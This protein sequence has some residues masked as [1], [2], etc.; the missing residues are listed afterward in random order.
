MVSKKG[1]NP[2]LNLLIVMKPQINTLPI[3]DNKTEKF[4]EQRFIVVHGWKF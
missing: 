2:C 3:N 4:E 1:V